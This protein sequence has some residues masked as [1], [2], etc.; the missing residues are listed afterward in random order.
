VFVMGFWDRLRRLFGG[1]AP[2]AVA[3]TPLEARIDSEVRSWA[4]YQRVFTDR[5]IAETVLTVVSPHNVAIVT[6]IIERLFPERA[7]AALSYR[8]ALHPAYGGKWVFHPAAMAEGMARQAVASRPAP[9]APA[10]VAAR[11]QPSAAPGAA[12]SR[13][14]EWVAEPSPNPYA[15]PEILGPS[16]EEMRRRALRIDPYKTAWIGRVDT[17]PPQSDERTALIDRGLILRGLLDETQI[18][19][20]HR[21]GD[22][23]LRHHDAVKLA[24]AAAA[25]SVEAAL[26]EEKKRKEGLKA[27]KK[28]EASERRAARAAEVARRRAEDV[29]FLGRGVSAGLRD[30]RSLVER[31]KQQDLPVLSTPADVARALGIEIPQLRWLAFHSEAAERTHYVYFDVPKRSGGTRHLAAPHER[32]AAAQRWILETILER[33]AVEEPAHGFVKR[34]STV[35]N[36]SPHVGRHVVVNLD[37][38]D[39]F[40]S[41]GFRRVRGVFRRLGYS[42]AVATVL[43]LLCTEAPRRVVEYDGRRYF[44][45]VGER[46]LP[47]GACTSPALSNQVARKLDRR[48]RGMAARGGWTYTRYADDLTFSARRERAAEVPMLMARVRHVV[49]EEGFAVNPRK[50]RVQRPMGRQEVTGIVVNQ[51]L[52]LRRDEVRRLR[53]ILHGARRSGLE[54][55]NREKIPHFEAWLRGKLAYLAMVDR[56]R[57]LA[58]LRE[59]DALTGRGA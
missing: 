54:A 9:L 1:G 36:A 11:P 57:G 21:V 5:D 59:L 58:Y 26:A 47:Q 29:I 3:A 50:G 22:L 40:P 56:P 2:A 4:A 8:R 52:S 55:Q 12:V 14:P 39:F 38:S 30:R 13:P 27:R 23:W 51:R 37:L 32:L 20:I 6:G 15:A 16:A 44:V 28:Q 48:L 19:E 46:A 41:I 53:A 18:A 25:G 33:L 10:P 31:L 45:A 24:E 42:E 43:A 34:R 49:E 7:L 35:T 17:I